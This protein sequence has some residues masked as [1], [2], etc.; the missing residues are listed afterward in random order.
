MRVS[1][2]IPAREEPFLRQTLDSLVA[3]A[4]GEIEILVGLDGWVPDGPAPAVP[5]TR[6]LHW[7]TPVGLRPVLN[8]LAAAA[9][10]D[11]LLKIDAHCAVSEGYDVALAAACGEADLVVPTKF[12]LDA[13]TWCPK[14]TDEPWQHFY[15]TFPYDNTLNHVGLH[16]KVCDRATHAAYADQPEA[17]ILSY[18]GSC[19]MLRKAWWNRI[20]PMNGAMY[21][22]A[23]EP[24]ELGLATW[25]AG[26][27]CR[28]VK[29]VWYAHLWK[30]HAHKRGFRTDKPKWVR[31]L[32]ASAEHWMA[33][34]GMPALIAQFWDLLTD[35]EWGPWP[36]DWQ[37]PK[38]KAASDAYRQE[39]GA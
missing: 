26:G 34:P 29:P 7:K 8:A 15:L 31:A 25:L 38:H 18:Q 28:I 27:R 37:D 39:H 22:T 35:V 24:Q 14:K 36:A 4:R 3:Q 11:Y 32:H 21:Y 19:W 17:D 30:G 33:Q 6:F 13:E 12:S 9:T 5:H 1:V 16:D 2:I 23:Q 20:G 10:G